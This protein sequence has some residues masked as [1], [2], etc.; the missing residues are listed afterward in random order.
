MHVCIW[1]ISIRTTFV[2]ILHYVILFINI[3]HILENIYLC[4]PSPSVFVL[5]ATYCNNLF[6]TI[7]F[8]F[9]LLQWLPNFHIFI[10]NVGK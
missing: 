10:T 8:L 2:Q 4:R 6:I 3:L 9:I 1:T 5:I 7:I